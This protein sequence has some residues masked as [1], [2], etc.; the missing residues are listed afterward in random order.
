MDRE[1]HHYSTIWNPVHIKCNN[2]ILL[3]WNYYSP[4]RNPIFSGIFSNGPQTSYS[5][6]RLLIGDPALTVNLNIFEDIFT[7]KYIYTWHPFRRLCTQGRILLQMYSDLSVSYSKKYWTLNIVICWAGEI[8]N[9]SVS[10]FS[11]I[12]WI[13]ESLISSH[14]KWGIFLPANWEL[15]QCLL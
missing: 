4:S 2:I 11:V 15:S 6:S 5:V 1:F 10:V 13:I 8:F 3:I 12:L 7:C 9:Y 14:N